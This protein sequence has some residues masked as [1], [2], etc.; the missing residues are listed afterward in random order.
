MS[1]LAVLLRKELTEQW[2][3]MRLP[4][5]M[6][7]FFCL[8]IASPLLARFTPD[9]VRSLAS[10]QLAALVPA[11]RLGDAVVQFVKNMSQFGAL[12]A[13]VLAMGSVA[14]ERERGTAAFVLSKPATRLQLL[15][16]KLLALTA[17][18]AAA[19]LVAGLAAYAYTAALFSSLAPGFA[20]TCALTLVG[21][22]V[23]TAVTFAASTVTGS[24]VAA[25]GVGFVALLA[26]GMLSVLPGV[27]PY[28][29]FGMVAQAQPLAVGGPAGWILWPLAVQVL[30]ICALFAASVLSFRRQEL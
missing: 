17:T 24:T 22:A 9:I 11:P 19:V 10:P 16:A 15:A 18:L 23:V 14:G 21:L 3:T 28:T 8:G 13:I 7:V 6:A 26:G 5:A 12:M 25:G 30:V 2:R 4:I 27:D 20:V 29:P 1:T